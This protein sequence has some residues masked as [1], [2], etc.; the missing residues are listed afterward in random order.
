MP[1][2]L[3]FEHLP[4]TRA[5]SWDWEG[6]L[7][8][9]RLPPDDHIF[10]I[11]EVRGIVLSLRKAIDDLKERNERLGLERDEIAER[12]DDAEEALKDVKYVVKPT[13]D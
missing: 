5:E 12:L 2:D 1:V 11:G 3:R 8:D 4:Y 9:G 13:V 6:R 10:S 7:A